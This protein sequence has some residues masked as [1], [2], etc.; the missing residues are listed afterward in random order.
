MVV[1]K[2]ARR[3]DEYALGLVPVVVGVVFGVLCLPR[4]V[5]PDEVPL[6]VARADVLHAIDAR[7]HALAS[8][9]VPLPDDVRTLGSAIRAYNTRQAKQEIDPFVTPTSMH[10]LRTAID[11]AA[12]PLLRGDRDDDVLAL[13]AT[14]LE[15][16]VREVRAFERTGQESEELVA[17]GGPFIKRMHDVGWCRDRRCVFDDEALRAMFRLAWNG[18]VEVARPPFTPSLDEQRALYAF[19]LRHPHAPEATR[20]RIDEA[21]R[22]ASSAKACAALDDGETRAA[23]DWRIEKVKRLAE[24][25][26]EYP[27]A[28][29]TG[30]ILFQEKRYLD[31]AGTF[32]D[33]LEAHPDG[34]WTLRARNYMRASLEAARP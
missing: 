15:G 23:S 5:L 20:S 33:W 29:A 12:A 27:A 25:D 16:F 18:L 13:R 34:A 32:H 28:Y 8:V 26:P 7:E 6:P 31:A 22:S 17:L 11:A 1:S 21:R 10:E 24:I 14:Q 2:G 9:P 30:V 19:Y 3:R 4:A